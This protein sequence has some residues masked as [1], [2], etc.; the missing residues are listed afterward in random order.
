MTVCQQV[1]CLI[2]KSILCCINKK[3]GV[4]HNSCLEPLKFSN[5]AWSMKHFVCMSENLFR[6]VLLKRWLILLSHYFLVLFDQSMN[7]LQSY[8][9]NLE[10]LAKLASKNKR[11]KGKSADIRKRPIL[12]KRLGCVLLLVKRIEVHTSN[13]D[14]SSISVTKRSGSQ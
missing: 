12:M 2:I 6:L 11:M 8:I 4:S 10:T 5:R 3:Y 13:V 7:D 1:G 14:N 9:I